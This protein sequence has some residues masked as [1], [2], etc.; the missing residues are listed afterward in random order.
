MRIEDLP[1][2]GITIGERALW[3]SYTNFYFFET[4][5]ADK[6]ADDILTE[7]ERLCTQ[8][9]NRPGST[10]TTDCSSFSTRRSIAQG[11]M[12]VALA[13]TKVRLGAL[14]KNDH[15]GRDQIVRETSRWLATITPEPWWWEELPTWWLTLK[16]Q[17]RFNS[18]RTQLTWNHVGV[19][20]TTPFPVIP[21]PD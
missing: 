13:A 9:K 18:I 3:S 8:D 16:R 12:L 10:P 20:P 7:M 5:E 11:P 2:Q 6:T 17:R 14:E 21:T 4:R 19:Y 15:K 1:Y